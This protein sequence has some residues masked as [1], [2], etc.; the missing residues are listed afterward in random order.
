MRREE[1]GE[2]GGPRGKGER[3]GRRKEDE[4][5]RAGSPCSGAVE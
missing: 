3:G 1:R 5:E 4:R 2:E